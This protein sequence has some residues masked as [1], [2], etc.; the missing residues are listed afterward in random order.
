VFAHVA[1]AWLVVSA[2]VIAANS[3]A[4]DTA[5]HREGDAAV[6]MGYDAKT[7]DAGYEW[8]GLHGT[9]PEVPESNPLRLNWWEGNWPTFRP[10]AVVSNS[11]LDVANYR[12]IHVNTSAYRR[13]LWFGNEEPLYLY[14]AL[15]DGCPQPPEDVLQE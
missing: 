1:F 13:F 11:Q 5:R 8:V 14:G 7:V 10:C 4:F 9:G 12:L 3:F 2:F 6:A 15:M